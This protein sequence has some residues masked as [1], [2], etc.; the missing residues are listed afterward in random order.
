MQSSTNH[1]LLFYVAL[2]SF[3][4]TLSCLFSILKILY[5]VAAFCENPFDT[6]W[7]IVLKN[8]VNKPDFLTHC[9]W[10][11]TYSCCMVKQPHKTPVYC[12]ESDGLPSNYPPQP[13]SKM[14]MVFTGAGQGRGHQQQVQ[15]LERDAALRHHTVLRINRGVIVVV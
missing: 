15:L 12:G 9:H 11:Q 1:K 6:R 7:F 5:F 3:L 13:L 14:L 2:F 10:A 4:K 8:N